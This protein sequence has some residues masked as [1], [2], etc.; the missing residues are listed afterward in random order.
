MLS[1]FSGEIA[2]VEAIFYDEQWLDCL[3]RVHTHNIV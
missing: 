3:S 2:C 1:N